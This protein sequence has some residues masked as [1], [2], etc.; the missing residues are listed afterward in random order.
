M[1]VA[2]QCRVIHTA[3]V[4]CPTD[5]RTSDIATELSGSRPG[6]S[7]GSG[8]MVEQFL[9]TWPVLVVRMILHVRRTQPLGFVDKRPLVEL[10]Q[11]LPL[12][13]ESLRDLRVVHLGVV[14]S[15][16]AALAT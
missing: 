8:S 10:R 15:D 9:A 1:I 13:A 5:R 2:S 3:S 16:A 6:G 7:A 12:G 14:E 11:T 4:S